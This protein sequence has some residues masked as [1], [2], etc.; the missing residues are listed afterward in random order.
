MYF[1]IDL[2]FLSTL[3]PVKR[4]T[5]LGCLLQAVSRSHYF[6]SRFSFYRKSPVQRLECNDAS[7]LA[8]YHRAVGSTMSLARQR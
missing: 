7:V 5:S 2:L 3:C 1:V 6:S 4:D 8:L